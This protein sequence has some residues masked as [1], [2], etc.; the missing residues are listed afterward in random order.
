M[1]CFFL[2]DFRQIRSVFS[3][4]AFQLPHASMPVHLHFA[5]CE[6]F[7]DLL[8][9]QI[10]SLRIE[11]VDEREEQE[12]EYAKVH[13]GAPSNVADADGSDFDDQEGEDP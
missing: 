13:I 4:A 10:S 8:K 1:L 5:T 3:V 11:Y 12:V 6:E 7:I 9:G 2:V